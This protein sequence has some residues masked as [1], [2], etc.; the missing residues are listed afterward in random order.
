MRYLLANADKAG[1]ESRKT[2]FAHIICEQP[3]IL[4]SF[5]F[6]DLLILENF[7]E[8]AQ[9]GAL[10][11]VS[12]KITSVRCSLQCDILSGPIFTQSYRRA[13]VYKVSLIIL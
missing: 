3:L 6:L 4:P 1:R 2:N 11:T 12:G 7:R 13:Q 10:V 5:G 8:E 9:A